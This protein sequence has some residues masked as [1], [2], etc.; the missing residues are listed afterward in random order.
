MRRP[1]VI[2]AEARQALCAASL[3]RCRSDSPVTLDGLPAVIRG[4]FQQFAKL[5]RADGRGGDVEFAWATVARV[6]E[7]GG[8]FSS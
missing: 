7:N 1:A 8:A 4:A 5:A 6:M 2:G 3:E